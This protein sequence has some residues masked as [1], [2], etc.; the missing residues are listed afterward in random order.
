MVLHTPAAFVWSPEFSMCSAG[1]LS[2]SP[3]L[4]SKLCPGSHFRRIPHGSPG[5]RGECGDE[6]SESLCPPYRIAFYEF[7]LEAAMCS[8]GFLSRSP[9]LPSKMAPGSH[10][11][12][13]RARPAH[14]AQCP[15]RFYN[16]ATRSAQC[17]ECFCMQTAPPI[18][19]MLERRRIFWC[20]EP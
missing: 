14:S 6:P 3:A 13:I 5:T 17:P 2:R 19:S 8:A 18:V 12:P 9:A 10:A 1:F 15:E 20:A 16:I 7:V 4:P 11:G